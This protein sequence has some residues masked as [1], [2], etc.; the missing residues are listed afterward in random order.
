ME[1]PKFKEFIQLVITINRGN[2]T[3]IKMFYELNNSLREVEKELVHLEPKVDKW[4]S[5]INSFLYELNELGYDYKSDYSKIDKWLKKY[6]TPK[7]VFLKWFNDIHEENTLYVILDTNLEFL[8]NIE[9]PNN[10]NY[11]THGNLSYPEIQLIQY[12]FEEFIKSLYV[13]KLFNLLKNKIKPSNK[14]TKGRKT[15]KKFKEYFNSEYRNKESLKKIKHIFHQKGKS[16]EVAIVTCLLTQY[17]L[18]T[19]GNDGRKDFFKAWFDFIENSYEEN[20]HFGGIYNFIPD[21]GIDG[22]VFRSI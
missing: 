18:V 14:T 2:S 5:Y 12:E 11:P 7:E 9:Y 22:F 21:K 15:H 10:T 8:S 20:H 1:N 16:K 4:E 13:Q 17:G 3:I 19:I 6:N